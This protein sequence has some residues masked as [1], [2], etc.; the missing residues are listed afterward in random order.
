MRIHSPGGLAPKNLTFGI[1]EVGSSCGGSCAVPSGTMRDSGFSSGSTN[2]CNK[3]TMELGGVGRGDK[4]AYSLILIFKLLPVQKYYGDGRS[5]GRFIKRLSIPFNIFKICLLYRISNTAIGDTSV[6]VLLAVKNCLF[7]FS[8]RV[9]IIATQMSPTH[10]T[11]VFALPKQWPAREEIVCQAVAQILNVLMRPAPEKKFFYTNLNK[12][13]VL[14]NK[15]RYRNSSK[16]YLF[17]LSI[18]ATIVIP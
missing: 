2:T 18:C 8:L 6:L 3:K 1:T 13:I 12:K 5:Y 9:K 15:G 10:P 17:F 7:Y 16:V 11:I 4:R 14:K